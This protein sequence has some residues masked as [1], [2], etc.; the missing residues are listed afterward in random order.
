MKIKSLFVVCFLVSGLNA[1]AQDDLDNI[2]QGSVK[3][4]EYLMKGYVGP[5]LKVLGTGLNQGW[6]NTA[7]AHKV[8]GFDITITASPV[9]FKASDLT[10]YVDNTKLTNLQ[11]VNSSNT[12]TSG[13]VPTALGS[14]EVT[15]R[16]RVV[17]DGV[18]TYVNG[19][20]GLGIKENFRINALPTPMVQL[21]FGL[22]KGTDL[23][24]RFSPK[25]Q[26][27]DQITFNMLGLGVMHDVK[28]W[29]PV[30]KNLPFDLSG[31]VGFT[32][33]KLDVGLDDAKP[34]QRGVLEA[35]A[36]NV[37]A[38]ISKKLSVLTV[39]GALG[40]NIAKTELA[41]KGTYDFNGPNDVVNPITIN[42]TANGFRATA[43]LRLKLAVIAFHGDYTL[44]K[45]N[46]LTLGFGINIR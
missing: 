19:P 25:F 31:F 36:W 4:A 13:N 29:I 11:L 33:L 7:K 46:T 23:K 17:Q 37:Q 22:P 21:G 34:D 5:V 16:Y 28:Q 12:P 1:I 26:I 2:I 39:Y 32:K 24:V 44:Q 35:N 18:T 9:Y 3:D 10:Y 30:I 43:G 42:E 40:Y 20:P 41:L 45:Y 15:P 38:I 14:D 27:G 8:A 6:Y